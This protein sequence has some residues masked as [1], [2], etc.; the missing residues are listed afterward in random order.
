MS[1]TKPTITALLFDLDG[2]LIN[3]LQA[4]INAINEALAYHDYPPLNREE[5]IR[6][7]WG[8]D[9]E[10]YQKQINYPPE[11]LADCIKFY[12]NH[13]HESTLFP[14]TIQTL[15]QLKDYKKAIV[16]NTPRYYTTKIVQDLGIKEYF[17]AILTEDDVVHAKPHPDMMNKALKLLDVSSKQALVIGDTDNDVN[18]A[19]QAGISTIGMNYPGADYTIHTLSELLP[20]LRQLKNHPASLQSP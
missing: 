15:D 17:D 3:S 7:F 20:L 18:S 12:A 6:Q 4:W 1:Q 2:T 10:F 5:F 8:K 9:R 14:D 11:V 19:Q 13:L 16:T